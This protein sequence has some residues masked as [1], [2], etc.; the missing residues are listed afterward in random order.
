MP[1]R[2]PTNLAV[3]V[4]FFQ[5]PP[6]SG[7]AASPEL[8]I[9]FALPGALAPAVAAWLGSVCRPHP[10]FHDALITSVYY[11][12]PE[13]SLLNEK[14]N[15]DFLKRKLRLRWHRAPGVPAGASP[16]FIEAKFKVGARR[17]KLRLRLDEPAETFEHT[18]LDAELFRRPL[19]LLQRHGVAG[20]TRMQPAFQISYRRLRYVHPFSFS[21]F[22]LDFQIAAPRVH[23]LRFRSGRPQPLAWAVFEQKGGLDELDPLLDGLRRHG[24]R[25]TSFSKYLHCFQHLTDS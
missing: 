21:T 18:P 10:Q 9:K 13:W 11:D 22:C 17:E 3:P 1:P 24:L 4:P 14:L 2:L 7:A 12:D 19:E 16:A 23:R 15:S 6:P 5:A 25:K 20:V 8:E